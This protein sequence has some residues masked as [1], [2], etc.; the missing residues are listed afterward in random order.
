LKVLENRADEQQLVT[1]AQRDPARFAEL[2]ESNFDR[3]YGYI[4]RRVTNRDDAEDLTAEVFHEAL[5]NLS[6]YEWRGLP[7]AAWLLGIAA[8]VLA[9][10]W[11]HVARRQSVFDDRNESAIVDQLC[12]TDP[13]IE[14]SA[15]VS[16]LVNDLPADQHL[17]VVRRFLD[18]K[19]VREIA[20]ELGRSEGAV[21][22]LQFRAL[23]TLRTRI[24]SCHVE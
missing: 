20:V 2:Y 9:D 19:S 7:F 22:Q 11:R 13:K 18:Q 4:A 23:Q 8:H 15:M 17:V 12:L 6:R 24:R 10:R 3:L 1:A 14:E 5:R 16:Q 21:K